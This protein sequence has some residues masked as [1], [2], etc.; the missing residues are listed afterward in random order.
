MRKLAGFVRMAAIGLPF[1][2]AV[3]VAEAQSGPPTAEE[4]AAQINALKQDYEKRIAA[5]EAQ[6]AAMKARPPAAA[7]KAA[8]ASR[9]PMRTGDNAFNPAIGVVLNAM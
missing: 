2:F 5:L 9:P 8:P 3:S 6:I 4:L 7:A 1:L